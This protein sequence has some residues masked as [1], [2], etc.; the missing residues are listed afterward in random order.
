MKKIEE[1]VDIAEAAGYYCTPKQIVAKAFNCKFKAQV[2]PDT[3]IRD[4]KRALQVEK[5]GQ[6]SNY[7]L[8]G[9]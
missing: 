4:W 9:K 2:L 6:I 7:T 8:L 5:P 1:T 3:V